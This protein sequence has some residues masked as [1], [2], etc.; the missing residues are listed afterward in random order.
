MKEFREFSKLV[1]AAPELLESAKKLVEKMH[2]CNEIGQVL[3]E[4]AELEKAIEK[5]EN[6]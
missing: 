6:K 4:L 1:L 3:S 5:A 2:V